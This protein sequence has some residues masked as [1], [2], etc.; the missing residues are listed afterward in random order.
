MERIQPPQTVERL[1][2]ERGKAPAFRDPARLPGLIAAANAETDDDRRRLAAYEINLLLE[3]MREP[4][5]ESDEAKAVLRELELKSLEGLL[6]TSGKSC[7]AEAVETLLACGF[8][9]ALQVAPEDLEHRQQQV[10]EEA[11]GVGAAGFLA[12]TLIGF[13]GLA[14]AYEMLG[15]AVLFGGLLLGVVGGLSALIIRS[16]RRRR[17]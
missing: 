2:D 8:P 3:A 5:N 16:I 6:D 13:G 12:L 10:R 14:V 1:D 15:G 4:G 7:R 17:A 11:R 9:H